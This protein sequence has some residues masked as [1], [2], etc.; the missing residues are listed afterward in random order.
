MECQLSRE[1]RPHILS[2]GTGVGPSAAKLGAKTRR[3]K[4]IALLDT[5]GA[6]VYW[7]KGARAQGLAQWLNSVC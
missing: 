3:S 5:W 7:G 1:Q 4:N 2:G 6:G